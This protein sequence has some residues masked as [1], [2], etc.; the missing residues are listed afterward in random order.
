ML[1]YSLFIAPFLKLKL[2]NKLYNILF[3]HF[4]S[5]Y[6]LMNLDKLPESLADL[7]K[8]K[9]ID[10]STSVI[11]EISKRLEQFIHPEDW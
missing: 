10:Y 8:L 1:D 9:N 5:S 2:G 4:L 6:F 7:P 11:K 3:R